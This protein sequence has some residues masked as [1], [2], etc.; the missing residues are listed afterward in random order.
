M[1]EAIREKDKERQKDL[2]EYRAQIQQQMSRQEEDMRRL[3]SS[4]EE[5]RREMQEKHERE[6]SEMRNQQSSSEDGYGYGFPIV[7]YVHPAYYYETHRG[8]GSDCVIL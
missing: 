1:E 7:Y 2:E 5:L 6:L 8:S 4:R 3:E